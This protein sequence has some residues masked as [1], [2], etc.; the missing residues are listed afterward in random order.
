MLCEKKSFMGSRRRFCRTIIQTGAL[1][2]LSCMGF[3]FLVGADQQEKQKKGQHKF[4]ENCGM[5]YEEVF[6]FAFQGYVY[7]MKA[8]AREIGKENLIKMLKKAASAA[9]TEYWKQNALKLPKRDLKTFI[10]PVKRSELMNHVLTYEFVEETGSVVEL[11]VTECLWATT[12][13]KF[14]ASDIGYVSNCYPDF[15][16]ASAFNPKMK[17]IRTKTLMQGHDCCNH[18]YILK[19]DPK[20][21]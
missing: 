2:C 15:A 14:A 12:Y 7:T 4:L 10:E 9:T 8:L 20:G 18:R 21:E 11:K 16:A 17:L 5:S 1:A 3:P 19:E 13:R 6:A